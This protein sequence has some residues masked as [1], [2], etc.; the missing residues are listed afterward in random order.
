MT[1]PGPIPKRDQIV[2]DIKQRMFDGLL[3]DG[4]RLPTVRSMAD[5]YNVGHV[6]VQAA[7]EQLRTEG[8]IR[9]EH[10]VGTFA[11]PG[12]AIWGPQQQLRAPR[13]PRGQR[14]EV[15]DAQLIHAP[16]YVAGILNTVMVVRR[17]ELTYGM[18]G[19]IPIH[20]TVS[21]TPEWALADVPDLAVLR[22]LDHPG[23]AAPAIAAATGQP[24]TRG[25]TGIEARAPRE[26]GREKPLLHLIGGAC[27]A[28]VYTWDIGAGEDTRTIEY[29]EIVSQP[30]SV[31]EF[32]LLP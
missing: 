21:W 25:W 19:P 31:L 13:Y 4:M 3:R 17:Q 22:P 24:I 15:T 26:D 2:A 30:N 27:L 8:L 14:V 23:G 10:G 1:E 16:R 20:L 6:T 18:A 9:T 5:D 29:R 32:Q 11:T 12:R 28:H 7:I